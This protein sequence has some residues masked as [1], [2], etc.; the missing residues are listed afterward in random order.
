MKRLLTRLSLTGSGALLG[1][2][3]GALIL[4]PQ[5]FLEM[6]HVVITPDPGLMSE[7]AA[8]AGLLLASSALM[9][10][11][12][13]RVRFA[14]LALSIGIIVYGSYGAGRLLSMMLNGLPSES[15]IAA[16][17]I[18]VMVTAGL[19]WLWLSW[20]SPQQRRIIED[21]SYD[22]VQQGREARS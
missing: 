6:S 1:V 15:L 7:L 22:A 3:G 2:I 11:G 16:T 12:A 17:V 21:G 14:T 10:Y 9:I 4:A 13:I 19:T 20:R 8:P 18:E 5:H